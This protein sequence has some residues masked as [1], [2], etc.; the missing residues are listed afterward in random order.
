MNK[1]TLIAELAESCELSPKQ[2]KAV[3][4]QLENTIERHLTK[5]GAGT[6]TLPGLL[7]ISTVHKP[8]QPARTGVPHPFTG[9][10][11]DVPAKPASMKVKVT[12]LKRLKQMPPTPEA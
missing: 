10:L 1:T 12:P 5:D 6:F 11:R 3:L 9:E 8:A 2:V 7:K 4:E